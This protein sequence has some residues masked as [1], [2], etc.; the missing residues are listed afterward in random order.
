MPA[1]WTPAVGERVRIESHA[2]PTMV[3]TVSFII[4]RVERVGAASATPVKTAGGK[5]Q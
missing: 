5:T 1:G 3:F 4:D 2:Q